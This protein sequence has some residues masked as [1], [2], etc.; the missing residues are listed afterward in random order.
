[1]S[2]TS[3]EKR[4]LA[5]IL[6]RLS[7]ADNEPFNYPEQPNDNPEEQFKIDREPFKDKYP[8]PKVE[9]VDDSLLMKAPS[10]K[11]RKLTEEEKK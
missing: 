11:R 5:S 8:A 10:K 2:I 3:E 1:M 6:V 9:I 7:E 4:K